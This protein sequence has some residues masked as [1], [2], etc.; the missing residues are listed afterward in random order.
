MY[1]KNQK[2]ISLIKID[3]KI[4]FNKIGPQSFQYGLDCVSTHMSQYD[5]LI[6]SC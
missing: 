2:N 4:K 3:K 1:L 6:A 5:N